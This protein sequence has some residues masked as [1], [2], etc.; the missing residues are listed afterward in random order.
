M[1]ELRWILLVLGVLF[2]AALA[3][4]ELRRPRQGRSEEEGRAAGREP[5][6]PPADA[7]HGSVRRL[8][9][10]TLTLP[11][12]RPRDTLREP[13]IV[14]SIDD[15]SRIGLRIDG[16]RIEEET[17]DEAEAVEPPVEP[18]VPA[19]EAP[20]VRRPPP[21]DAAPEPVEPIVEWPEESLRKILALRLVAPA[22]ERFP[23]RTLRQ[24]LAAEG[25]VLGKFSIFHKPGPDA[26]AVVSA[27]SL[28]RPGTFDLATMDLQ[29][30][31]G[32]SLFAVLPGPLPASETF[33][34]LL[35]TARNLNTRLRGTLQDEHGQP[36]TPARV[37][38]I[39]ESLREE[40]TDAAAAQPGET[41]S[42]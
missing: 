38:A 33:D 40:T 39:R 42:S 35:A 1:S 22:P 36:L 30:F 9:E 24:A 41:E 19:P 12:I 2:I 25:F 17:G 4:W 23:G 3:W 28:T 5:V 37:A 7:E 14:E 11:E 8:R 21:L 32:L 26:R 27:A 13:A 31:G 15:D 18:I 20:H 34:E 10:P 29:R 16:D 6:F